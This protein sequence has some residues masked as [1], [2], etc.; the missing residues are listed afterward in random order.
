MHDTV[1]DDK[2]GKCTIELV[3]EKFNVR[4]AQMVNG[5]TKYQKVD[6]KE[7]K[8]TL[9]ETLERLHKAEDYETFFIKEMDRVHN[10]Q[11]ADGLKPEK[12]KKMAEETTKHMLSGVAYV[13]EKLGIHEKFYFENK[14]FKLSH[15]ILKSKKN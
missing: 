1:E 7:K 3:E 9:K 8:L 5:L 2:T 4:I 6:G 10:L 14:L 11:T 13:A 15:D 12:R